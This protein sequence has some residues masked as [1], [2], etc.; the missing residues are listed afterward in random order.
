[1]AKGRAVESNE[2]C[3]H[4][5]TGTQVPRKSV[6]S[7]LLELTTKA[8]REGKYR[9]RSLYREIDLRM[10]YGPNRGAR[11]ASKKLRDEL[12]FGRVHWIVEADI[13]GFCR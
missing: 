4:A 3:T 11:E 5:K 12:F 6:S 8:K 7:T 9:F 10:L 13:K 1:M 2:Q